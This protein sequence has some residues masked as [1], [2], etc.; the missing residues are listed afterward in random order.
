MIKMIENV[1]KCW[2]LGIEL[3]NKGKE[4][5]HVVVKKIDP[6]LPKA[7]GN[8]GRERVNLIFLSPSHWF[9]RLSL[10]L[11]HLHLHR[12]TL[13]SSLSL[14]PP[15]LFFPQQSLFSFSNQIHFFLSI[16]YHPMASASAASAVAKPPST[17]LPPRTFNYTTSHSSLSF[18][19]PNKPK[20]RIF[21]RVCANSS[22]SS[23]FL[24]LLTRFFLS[25]FSQLLSFYVMRFW[26]T[27][28]LQFFL[29]LGW[30]W[31]SLGANWFCDLERIWKSVFGGFFWMEFL[32]C[33]CCYIEVWKRF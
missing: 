27:I 29:F 33:F 21:T 8:K 22:S 15:F 6:I 4:K 19:L 28:L 25:Y 5:C 9:H 24:P 30:F 11:R 7:S 26:F 1:R 12:R 20:L 17:S 14:S 16:S 2:E 13:L 10:S 32:D 23:F 18:R 31:I 3:R